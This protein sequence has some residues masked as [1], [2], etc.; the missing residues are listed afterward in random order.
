VDALSKAGILE[1]WQDGL[2]V[3]LKPDTHSP[4]FLDLKGLFDK[5]AGLISVLQQTT[6]SSRRGINSADPLTYLLFAHSYSASPL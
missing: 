2:R 4:V 6:N 5:T 3:Y 1:R